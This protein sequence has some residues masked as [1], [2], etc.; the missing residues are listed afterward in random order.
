MA[1]VYLFGGLHQYFQFR[2]TPNDIETASYE[3][4]ISTTTASV[5]TTVFLLRQSDKKPSVDT[6]RLVRQA[7]HI[8]NQAAVTLEP[9][10]TEMI[11]INENVSGLQLI[12]DSQTLRGMLPE[13]SPDRLYIVL[14]DGLGGVNGVAFSGQNIVAVAEY[15]TSFDFRVLAHEV[16]HALGLSH[17]SYRHNLMYSGSSGTEL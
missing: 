6:D 12:S 16:G 8:I 7:N 2:Q 5:P 3:P 4:V 14:V 10:E 1:V 11:S 17:V 13:L 15:T 9:V